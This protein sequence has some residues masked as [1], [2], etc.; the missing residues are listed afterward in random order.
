MSFWRFRMLITG[1]YR[2]TCGNRRGCDVQF[3]LIAVTQ[4]NRL[5]VNNASNA[6]LI[7]TRSRDNNT[8]HTEPR[9]ARL[10]ETMMFAAAR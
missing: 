2:R 1:G 8:L 10:L 5:G 4:Q 7:G 3:A 9:A 6:V